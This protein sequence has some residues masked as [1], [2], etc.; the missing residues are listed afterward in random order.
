VRDSPEKRIQN[1]I[2]TY[3]V[4]EGAL[5]LR[6]NSG[7]ASHDGPNQQRR[8]VRFAVWQILGKALASAGV[9]DILACYRGR[10]I[11]IEVKTPERRN[12]ISDAQQAFLEAV[13][14]AGGVAIVATE[15]EQVRQVVADV[16]YSNSLQGG[17]AAKAA[18]LKD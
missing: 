2:F 16:A 9:A 17:I 14:R 13:R 18:L 3:L 4:G 1:R 15:V 11:A 10:F 8:F 12:Y 5:A 7:A 6:I